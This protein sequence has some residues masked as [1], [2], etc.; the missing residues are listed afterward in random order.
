MTARKAAEIRER[1]VRDE[2]TRKLLL[3]QETERRRIAGE[4]HD[5]LGQNL[6]L[7]K[8]RA[9]LAQDTAGTPPQARKQFE[10]L[11]ELVSQAIAEVRQIS[12]DLRPHQLDQLGLTLALQAMI[13][14]AAQSSHLAIER[15]LDPVDDLFAPEDATH[16]Y[17]VAQESL[18]NILK[19]A[20]ARRAKVG[21]ERDV[22][23]VRLW[24]EDDGQ[25]FAAGPS[26]SGL[27]TGGLGLSSIAERVR[28]LGGHLQIKSVPGF[29]TRI[30][31]T[32]PQA[33]EA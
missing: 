26:K 33:V 1:E 30:E 3:S 25:G 10:D 22:H 12:H 23:N 11:K 15:K 18:S 31:I 24:I 5:S 4:L 14:G 19:H 28:I 6:I 9:Q 32:I 13:D 27:P 17:R 16:V 20:N 21:L 7:L 8:N 29:G 2:F